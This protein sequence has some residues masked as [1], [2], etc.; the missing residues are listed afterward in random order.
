MYRL[1][2]AAGCDPWKTE[3]TLLGSVADINCRLFDAWLLR[4]FFEF[5]IA[6][7]TL[8]LNRHHLCRYYAAG[9]ETAR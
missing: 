1:E 8:L 6:P 7:S 9:N 4:V 5:A 2:R 3:A